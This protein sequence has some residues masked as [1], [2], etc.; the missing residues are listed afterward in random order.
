MQVF[1]SHDTVADDITCATLQSLAQE[2]VTINATAEYH[3][4]VS[5][6][7]IPGCTRPGDI[8]DL[9]DASDG[10]T[11]NRLLYTLVTHDSYLSS[12]IVLQALLPKLLRTALSRCTYSGTIDDHIQTLIADLWDAI[13]TYPAHLTEYVAL[14]LTRRRPEPNEPHLEDLDTVASHLAA[15]DTDTAGSELRHILN[16][17]IRDGLVSADE[18]ALLIEVYIQGFSP[19]EAAE[20]RGITAPAIRKRCERARTRLAALV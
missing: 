12:R 18:V 13:A 16:S 5:T 19:A 14:N 20:R 7:G 10:N 6:L 2:W 4:Q 8:L 3:R 17:G 15:P 9:I 1:R 11:A